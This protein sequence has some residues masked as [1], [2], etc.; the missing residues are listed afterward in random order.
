MINPSFPGVTMIS[1]DFT[2]LLLDLLR[3]LRRRLSSPLL[4]LIELLLPLVWAVLRALLRPELR[5][6]VL[7]ELL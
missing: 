1:I 4:R 5:S 3:L 7:D 6:L 2:F